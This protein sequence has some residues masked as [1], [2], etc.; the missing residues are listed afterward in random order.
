[1]RRWTVLRWMLAGAVMLSLLV[2]PALYGEESCNE[3]IVKTQDAQAL[4]DF[5]PDHDLELR[6]LITYPNPSAKVIER[7]G[8]YWL[9]SAQNSERTENLLRRLE[10]L[11][12]VERV[13]PNLLQHIE[14]AESRSDATPVPPDT[15]HRPY[16]PND[17]MFSDQWDKM[18]TQ[19]DWA[20]NLTTGSPDVIIA[21]LDTGADTD[22]E[23]L[24]ANLV[25]G[26]NFVSGTS[27]IEDDYGHGTHVSGIAAAKIDNSKG[28]AGMAGNASIMPIKVAD[29]GGDYTNADLAQGIIYAAEEGADVVNMSLGGTHSQVLEDAVNYAW[30]QG[31]FLCAAAGNKRE[32]RSDYPAAYERVASVGA[33]TSGDSRWQYSNYGESVAIF[34]PGGGYE[35][36]LSTEKGG[37]YGWRDGTSM[38]CPQVAGLAALI[39]GVHPEYTNQDVWDKMIASADTIPFSH[40]LRINSRVALDVVEVAED[41]RNSL[42]IRCAEIQKGRIS[43]TCRTSESTDYDLRI[44]DV[45]GREVYVKRGRIAPQGRIES[46]PVIPQGVYFWK[47]RTAVGTGSGRF[48]Y[49]H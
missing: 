41:R 17:P 19:T 6:P 43:F 31:L 20:W 7:F 26:Y 9:A 45:T 25:P 29:S 4:R 38:A 11:P 8:C 15:F 3:F 10:D 28:I 48:V 33:T 5:A 1:M 49:L 34:A 40:E 23:D 18:I 16:T 44:F 12:G 46:N 22:H 30:G 37:Y 32:E 13:E 2:P 47:I 27:D 24:Q 35:G 14:F 39:A 36:I 42:K 21:I